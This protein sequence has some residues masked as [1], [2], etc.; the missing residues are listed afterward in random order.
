[1]KIERC[2]NRRGDSFGRRELFG[3][4]DNSHPDE[5]TANTLLNV[6]L[7]DE[8]FFDLIWALKDCEVVRRPDSGI[9]GVKPQMGRNVVPAESQRMVPK[10]SSFTGAKQN[11]KFTTS[12][13]VSIA[14][15]SFLSAGTQHWSGHGSSL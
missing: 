5:R 1:M 15:W 10:P 2:R 8:F 12:R 3:W 14:G 4:I 11:G 9:G 13:V 6:L 7:P